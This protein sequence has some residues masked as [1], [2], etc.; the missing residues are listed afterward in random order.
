MLRGI[1]PLS[2]DRRFIALELLPAGTLTLELSLQASL[3]GK[4]LKE[5]KPNKILNIGA[6]YR[7]LSRI[8]S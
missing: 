8:A 2:Q 6:V 1:V 4:N 5:G 3:H 7:G